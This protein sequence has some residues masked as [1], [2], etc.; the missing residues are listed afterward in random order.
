MGSDPEVLTLHRLREV[1]LQL[2]YIFV[3]VVAIAEI[4]KEALAANTG[5]VPLAAC[6]P[7]TENVG[8]LPCSHLL[9]TY[10]QQVP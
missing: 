10:L 6:L 7:A 5:I 1:G 4:I 3:V 2:L 9:S 8:N